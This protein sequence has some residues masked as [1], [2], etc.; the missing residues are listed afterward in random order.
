MSHKD[1]DLPGA[2]IRLFY[3]LFAACFTFVIASILFRGSYQGAAQQI[4]MEAGAAVCFIALCLL[5]RLAGRYE[6]GLE[7][8]YKRILIIFSA[9]MFALEM[10]L[11]LALRHGTWYDV[12]ALHQGAAEW[13]ETGTFAGFYEYY[14]YF[15]NNLGGMTFLY[16]FFKAASLAGFTDYYAVASLVTCMMLTSM[17]AVASLICKRLAGIKSAVLSLALFALSAQFWVLGG[18]VYTDTLSMLFPVLIFYLYLLAREKKGWGRVRLYLLMGLAAG[19][20]SLNKI[21]VLIMAV[22]VLIDVCLRSEWKE[23]FKLAVCV[24]G[25]A[26]AMHMA[27]NACLYS[28]HLS[29]EEAQRNNTPLLH[30]VMM[31]LKGNGRY[32]AEDYAFTR[33]LDPEKR[34]TVLLEEIGRRVRERGVSGM[35]DL[36]SQKSAI[37]FGDGTYGAHDFLGITPE[38]HTWLHD[39]VLADGP[40]YWLY[41][42]YTTALHIAL[43]L[44]MLIAAYRRFMA[45]GTRGQEEGAL[46]LPLYAAVFGVWLFLLFWEANPRYFS[47]FAPVI[48]VCGVLG[49]PQADIET[50]RPA[51]GA[52]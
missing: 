25:L 42:G 6:R 37:D 12:G 1:L 38:R 31:G 8:N 2:L 4:A 16:V 20:G 15:P 46:L 32:N 43:M 49:I 51:G 30:W 36:F 35:V 34:G 26:A 19:V 3:L 29:R 13:A 23:L 22:A 47:N 17:M 5:D 45:G 41:S 10:V 28:A 27:L 14:G 50:K 33:A 48:I 52:G 21:T 40:F 18:A 11:A 7:K 39:F 24:L 44:F 9:A